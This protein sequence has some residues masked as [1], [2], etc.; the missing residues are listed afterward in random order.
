MLCELIS[1]GYV[2]P[3]TLAPGR[4]QIFRDIP[5]L[6]IILLLDIFSLVS[7]TFSFNQYLGAFQIADKP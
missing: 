2:H 1:Q 4:A 6:Q 3:L 7:G 5:L